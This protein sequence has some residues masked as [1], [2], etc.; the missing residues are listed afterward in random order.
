MSKQNQTENTTT[1]ISVTL[2]GL[3]GLM[4]D[5]FIDHSKEVRPAEQKLY[6]DS[7]GKTLVIPS[8]MIESFLTRQLA[9]VGCAAKFEGKRRAEYASTALSH[10]FFSPELIPIVEMK[11]KKGIL[12]ESELAKDERFYIARFS[13]ITKMSGGG[14]IKQEAKPRPVLRHGWEISFE[15]QLIKNT[16]IDETKL[17]NWFSSGGIVIGLGSYRPRYGRFE[18]TKWEIAE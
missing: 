4:F 6:L 5:R 7:D 13:P 8:M 11:T 14:A 2:T 3:S 17:Y 12:I 18:V 9:P 15:I 16:L 10:V 1:R